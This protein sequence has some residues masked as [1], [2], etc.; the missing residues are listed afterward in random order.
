MLCDALRSSHGLLRAVRNASYIGLA[1]LVATS[2][3]GCPGNGV[4]PN[5]DKEIPGT[6]VLWTKDSRILPLT[7]IKV[8]GGTE[9][10]QITQATNAAPACGAAGA[11]SI[12]APTSGSTELEVFNLPVFGNARYSLAATTD[13]HSIE[14]IFVPVEFRI[15]PRGNGSGQVASGS[16]AIDCTIVAGAIA[17]SGC[18]STRTLGTWFSLVATAS[19]GSRFVGYGAPCLSVGAGATCEFKTSLGSNTLIVEFALQ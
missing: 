3:S 7:V 1:C 2:I 19:T 8:D 12:G 10:G 18:V 13:C 6:Y 9:L 15:V 4:G 17:T 14:V 16:K 11:L 5:G